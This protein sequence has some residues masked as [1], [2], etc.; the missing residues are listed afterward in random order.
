MVASYPYDDTSE[1]QGSGS[2]VNSASPDDDFFIYVS[3]IYSQKHSFMHK[4][5]GICGGDD[6]PGGITNGAHW[7][8]T[9]GGKG[10]LKYVTC[11]MYKDWT[12]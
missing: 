5:N 11:I 2:G 7:Y 10:F 8:E 1:R 6:F 9:A 12:C 3:K 4:G